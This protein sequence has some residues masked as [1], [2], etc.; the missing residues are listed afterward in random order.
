MADPA[1]FAAHRVVT[2]VVLSFVN[3]SGDAEETILL[4]ACE[5]RPKASLS[6]KSRWLASEL[7]GH[8]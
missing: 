7:G 1:T 4:T 8:N 3:R 5:M 6:S 2:R